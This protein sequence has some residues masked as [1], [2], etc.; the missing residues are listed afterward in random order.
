M[1][2]VRDKVAK[3]GEKILAGEVSS[4][5]IQESASLYTAQDDKGRTKKTQAVGYENSKVVITII[6]ESTKKKSSLKQIKEI[7]ALFRS[8]GQKKPKMMRI[9]NEDCSAR[10]IKKVYFKDFTTKK[11][12]SESK[13]V[14]TLELL[15]PGTAS[16]TVSK[17]KKGE[18]KQKKS[19]SK[20]A[21]KNR[22]T[23]NTGK[24]PAKDTRSTGEGKKAARHLTKK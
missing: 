7:E 17:K 22:S 5:E 3:L 14:A 18:E 4:V 12:I 8:H 20:S 24:S 1:L 11:I 23:K 19:E 10:G 6:L 9:V 21:S 2:Y 16:T 15:V 13:R